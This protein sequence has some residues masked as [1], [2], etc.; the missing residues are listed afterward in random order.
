MVKVIGI[1]VITLLCVI[2]LRE[3]NK[4]FAIIVSVSGVCIIFGIIAGQLSGV[5]NGIIDLSEEFNSSIPYIKIM[6][7]VLGITLSAQ[8]VSNICSDNGENA[9][10]SITEL[11]AKI[12]IIVLLFPL[13]ETLISII[14][15][16]VK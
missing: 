1:S 13:F 4:V 2:L 10:A 6:L 9:L 16:L 7:K 11:T 14:S 5:I 15:G 8:I 12:L 3:K